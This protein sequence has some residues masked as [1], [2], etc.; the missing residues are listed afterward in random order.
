MMVGSLQLRDYPGEIVRL[1][2]PRFGGLTIE[3]PD[4]NYYRFAV[5][6]PLI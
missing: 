6:R 5:R 1:S 4:N 3:T 2:C